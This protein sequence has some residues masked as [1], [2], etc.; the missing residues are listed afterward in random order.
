MTIGESLLRRLKNA[1]PQLVQHHEH[2]IRCE[3]GISIPVLLTWRK[4]LWDWERD[5]TLPNP[6]ESRVTRELVSPL[7]PVL[8]TILISHSSYTSCY[9]TK[10]RG[11]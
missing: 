5:S 11:G 4:E 6:F 1:G 7:A 2:C 8:L 9:S 3:K 10:T